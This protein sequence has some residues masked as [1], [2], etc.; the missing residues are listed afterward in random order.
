[1][2]YGLPAHQLISL[3]PGSYNVRIG[4]MDRTTQ[5]IGTVDAPLVVTGQAVAQR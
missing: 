3:P 4:V 5:E 2:N 1:L